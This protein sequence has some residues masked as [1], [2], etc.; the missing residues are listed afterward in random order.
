MSREIRSTYTA[1]LNPSKQQ[2]LLQIGNKVLSAWP[3]PLRGY[4]YRFALVDMQCVN[5]LACPAGHVFVSEQLYDMCETDLELESIIAHEIAHVEM[6]HGLRQLNRAKRDAGILSIFGAVVGA[7]ISDD[8]TGTGAILGAVTGVGLE[9]AL[10]IAQSG[11]SRDMEEESDSYAVNYLVHVMGDEARK[12]YA[13]ALRKLE[14]YEEARSQK[15][16]EE[17]SLDT[18]PGIP[19]RVR[20]AT[21]SRVTPLVPP[22]VFIALDTLGVEVMRIGIESVV[23]YEWTEAK[24]V[25]RRD[26]DS[27]LEQPE[28]VVV[29]T[30]CRDISVFGFAEAKNRIARDYELKD[31]VAEYGSIEVKLDNKEDTTVRPGGATSLYVFRKERTEAAPEPIGD[32]VPLRFR[33]NAGR[34]RVLVFEPA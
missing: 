20:F 19:R 7:V 9:V 17:G 24:E 11:Y 8:K 5:A 6:R 21:D 15:R 10:K 25:T 33:I 1:S 28:E 30:F 31:L 13:S 16:A 27:K 29:T 34:S 2:R 32:G 22:R 23:V 3:L 12:E 18:H 26:R 4:E 14:Y